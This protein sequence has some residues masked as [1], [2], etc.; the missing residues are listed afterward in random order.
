LIVAPTL[1]NLASP[2]YYSSTF[3]TYNINNPSFF[4]EEDSIDNINTKA[5]DKSKTPKKVPTNKLEV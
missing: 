3:N 2:T 1:V 5:K 4:I